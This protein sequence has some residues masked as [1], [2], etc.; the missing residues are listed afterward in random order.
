MRE[1]ATR[2]MLVSAAEKASG[3]GTRCNSG[4]VPPL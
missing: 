3:E 1:V 2:W 4:T